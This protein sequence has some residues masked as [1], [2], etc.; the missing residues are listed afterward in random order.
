MQAHPAEYIRAFH[1]PL[2]IGIMKIIQKCSR[3]VHPSTT[4]QHFQDQV[5]LMGISLFTSI[6]KEY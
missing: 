3:A 6:P 2:I 5:W 1:R 4:L